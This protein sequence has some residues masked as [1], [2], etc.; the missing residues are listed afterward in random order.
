LLR[1]AGSG[2]LENERQTHSPINFVL[3][4][5]ELRSQK[6]GVRAPPLTKAKWNSPRRTPQQAPHQFSN[7]IMGTHTINL[8]MS[9]SVRFVE[10]FVY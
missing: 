9:T 3:L 7:L 2:R 1:H 10:E 8:K 4:L 6:R 5:Q